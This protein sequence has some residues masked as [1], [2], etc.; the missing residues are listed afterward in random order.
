MTRL[1]FCN[2]GIRHHFVGF[3]TSQRSRKDMLDLVNYH[4]DYSNS[5]LDCGRPA[6]KD[7][8]SWNHVEPAFCCKSRQDGATG[9]RCP[10]VQSLIHSSNR[11]P[12]S[13]IA[14]Y[15]FLPC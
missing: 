2:S 10:R 8:R 13:E 15:A 1:S 12:E 6:A 11:C 3:L 9:R 14:R 4:P 7:E 5:S